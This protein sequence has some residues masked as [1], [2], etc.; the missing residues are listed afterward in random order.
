[1]AVPA[2]WVN[3][4]LPNLADFLSFAIGELS[5]P[6]VNLPSA[7]GTATSATS[8][9]LTD[10]TQT[11]TAAQWVNC[12][13]AD[14]TANV[15][16][17]VTSNTTDTASFAPQPSPLAAGDAYVIVQPIVYTAL[18]V[19][20][21]IV[22]DAL[23]Q[24]TPATYTLAV[25]NLA[26]DRLVRFAPDQANQSYFRQLRTQFGLI[27]TSV[28]AVASASDQGT[29]AAIA[30]PDWMRQMTMRDIQTLRTPWGREY[31]G[32][33]QAWGPYVWGVS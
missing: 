13:L 22:N 30:N 10:T 3:P 5:D 23:A 9:S 20:L 31:M 26:M 2:P 32:F 19:A 28:G 16:V 27:G 11:W 14:A 29:S 17:P 25:Y 18:T 7:T 4:L 12:W 33:V 8:S 21:A 6:G 24:A 1:M 15:T